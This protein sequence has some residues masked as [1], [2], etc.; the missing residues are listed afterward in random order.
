MSDNKKNNRWLTTNYPQIVFENSKVGRLKK[1][2]FDAPMSKIEEILKEYKI[3]SA[4]ELGE[5][6]KSKGRTS[7]LRFCLFKT[8]TDPKYFF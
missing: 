4:S 8:L 1:E 2:I 7:L 6:R 5:P 3:P